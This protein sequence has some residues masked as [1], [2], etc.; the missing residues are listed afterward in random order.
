MSSR[1]IKFVHAILTV[2]AGFMA[3]QSV[4]AEKPRVLFGCYTR[5]E[6]V[7][8]SE[9]VIATG[10]ALYVDQSKPT[11]YTWQTTGGRLTPAGD[12]ATINTSG[13]A[14]GEYTV[15]GKL[16]QGN[17]PT[18]QGTCT[19]RFKVIAL[20]PPSVTCRATPG[21]V[22]SGASVDINN[23]AISPQNRPFS[24]SFATSAGKLTSNGTLAKLTTTNVAAGTIHVTCYAVD[25][26]GASASATTDITITKP[27]AGR[28]TG[29]RRLCSL[30]FARDRQ[31]PARVDGPS[32]NC[33]DSIASTLQMNQGSR[34]IV[35]GNASPTE[36]PEI[37]AERAMN[38]RQYLTSVK[39]IPAT[40]I[41]VRVGVTSGPTIDNTLIPPGM[42]FNEPNTQLFDESAI[43]RHGPPYVVITPQSRRYGSTPYSAAPHH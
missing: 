35:V 19:A 9:S 37:S 41:Q 7:H 15:T 32:E 5:P 23:I 18:Q 10:S 22:P 30:S 4:R 36:A 40:R 12:H 29:I 21:T 1:P 17:K 3:A 25:D 27:L 43:V 16:V 24:Y 2:L 13:L 6:T 20:E 31:Y 33:L 28:D 42:E 11:D 14:P 38:E 39:G 8:A 26:K 34:L